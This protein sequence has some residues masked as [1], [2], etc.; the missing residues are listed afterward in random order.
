MLFQNSMFIFS[1]ICIPA[2]EAV[3][4]FKGKHFRLEI[5]E[6]FSYFIA[7]TVVYSQ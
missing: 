5:L 4:M 6:S 3:T 2:C 7:L 1:R